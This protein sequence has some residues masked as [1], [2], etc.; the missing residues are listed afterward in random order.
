MDI[1]SLECLLFVM[2][3]GSSP[4]EIELRLSLVE[5]FAAEATARLK[6]CTQ[7]KIL[8]RQVPFPHLGC[9]AERRYKESLKELVRSMLDKVVGDERPTCSEVAT[10][11]GQLLQTE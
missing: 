8:V 2:M 7:R 4:F 10:R 11:V 6:A 5:A 9:A 3:Y 1:W